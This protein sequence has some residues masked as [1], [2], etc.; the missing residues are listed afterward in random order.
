[1]RI[2]RKEDLSLHFYIKNI[3]LRDFVETEET[4]ELRLIS[5][6]YLN[7]YYAYEA[8]VNFNENPVTRGRGW[9]YFDSPIEDTNIF[10]APF[11]TISGVNGAGEDCFGIPEQSDRVVLYNNRSEE[12]QWQDYIIDYASGRVI[13]PYKLKNPR[14]TYTWNYVSVIDE[15]PT[16]YVP[17]TP[18]VV[19][20]ITDTN[21]QGYQLGHGRKT[22]RAVDVYVFASNPAERSDLIETLHDGFYNKGCTLYEF[23]TGTTLDFD[24]TFYGRKHLED[25]DYADKS[26]NK[27]LFDTSS[28]ENVSKLTFDSVRSRTVTNSL[29]NTRSVGLEMLSDLNAYRGKVSFD[30]SS[31]DDRV[32]N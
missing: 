6:V 24:G 1:M 22:T 15:W 14:I 13:T 21:K 2:L 26:K 12:L 7:D 10:C 19:L 3:I 31:Y 27:Y 20:D 11:T 23:K 29:F 4:A 9:V 28:V 18:I 32:I 16:N 5:D 8:V 17:N 30:M 25:L